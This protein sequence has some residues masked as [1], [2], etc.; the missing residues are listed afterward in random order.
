MWRYT[1]PIIKAW[2]SNLVKLNKYP[3]GTDKPVIDSQFINESESL[4][5]EILKK[6]ATISKIVAPKN[7]DMLPKAEPHC[8]CNFCQIARAIHEGVSDEETEESLPEEEVSDEELSFKEWDIK[9]LGNDMYEVADPLNKEDNFKVCMS[10]IGCT[11]GEKD[12][13]HIVAVLKS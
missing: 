6:I 9:D 10:P 7:S 3:A 4:P 13:P 1:D 11:C 12:C 5:K 8:N 2:K